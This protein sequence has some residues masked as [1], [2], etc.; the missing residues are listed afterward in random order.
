MDIVKNL[1][2]DADLPELKRKYWDNSGLGVKTFIYLVKKYHRHLPNNRIISALFATLFKCKDLPE[3]QA[4]REELVPCFD[5][6]PLYMGDEAWDPKPMWWFEDGE[7]FDRDEIEFDSVEID[8]YLFCTKSKSLFSLDVLTTDSVATAE[9]VSDS[10]FNEALPEKFR[11]ELDYE[12]NREDFRSDPMSTFLMKINASASFEVEEWENK[13]YKI[14]HKDLDKC[15]EVLSSIK[16]NG[17]KNKNDFYSLHKALLNSF[18]EAYCVPCV[19]F[20]EQ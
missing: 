3:V 10:E 12:L 9:A 17:C 11:N 2:V 13:R 5:I 7:D 4:I 18:K 14:K 6:T 16:S 20:D 19:K 1:I 8:W 15:Y